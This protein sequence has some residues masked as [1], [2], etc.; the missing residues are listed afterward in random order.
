MMSKSIGLSSLALF[1]LLSAEGTTEAT[2]QQGQA[3]VGSG[4]VFGNAR[5]VEEHRRLQGD[6]CPAGS[7]LFEID[8]DI[9]PNGAQIP[10]GTY[11]NDQYWSYGV[12]IQALR[13]VNG[14]FP[15]ASNWARTFNS[16][17][18]TGGDRDLG[19]P[20]KNC[21]GCNGDIIACPGFARRNDPGFPIASVN[22]CVAQNNILIIHENGIA[23]EPDD[24]NDG[25]IFEFMFS[26]PI[27]AMLDIGIMDV[28]VENEGN[29]VDLLDHSEAVLAS[30]PF[31]GLGDNTFQQIDFP[32]SPSGISKVQIHVMTSGALTSFRYCGTAGQPTASPEESAAPTAAPTPVPRCLG[33]CDREI[34]YFFICSRDTGCEGCEDKEASCEKMCR[35]CDGLEDNLYGGLECDCSGMDMPTSPPELT[36]PDERTV[37]VDFDTLPDGTPITPGTFITDQFQAEYGFEVNAVRFLNGTGEDAGN[38]ARIFDSSN[39][40]GGDRDLGSPNKNCPECANALECPGFAAK[41]SEGFFNANVTN[42]VAQNNVLIIEEG[43]GTEEPDDAR[44]G[45]LVL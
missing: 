35:R 36:C 8:W 16:S 38:W 11:M 23:D 17:F 41:S 21:A 24:N 26:P 33:S 15:D 19:S 22:N 5:P 2:P 40:T 4:D 25:G 39:P 13:K 14:T 12:E 9:A 42:C 44:F 27:V 1:A 3:I 30:V 31:D 28:E 18:P 6:E 37:T 45:K 10:V 43:D 32:S 29:K 34:G 20:N 7:T